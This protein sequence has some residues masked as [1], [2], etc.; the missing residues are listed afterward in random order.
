MRH[1]YPP[2]LKARELA[3]TL[4]VMVSLFAV[5]GIVVTAA[6]A[7]LQGTAPD[8]GYAV[9]SLPTEVEHVD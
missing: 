9:C 5:V 1:R 7:A 4:I 8:C 3:L 2:P 6:R